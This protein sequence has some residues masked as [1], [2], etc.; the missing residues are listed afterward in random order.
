[1]VD[2]RHR[3][4][5]AGEA[6]AAE[7][8]EIL[9]FTIEDRNARVGRLEVDIVARDEHGFVVAEVR[10]RKEN[11]PVDPFESM[12]GAKERNI[13]NALAMMDRTGKGRSVYIGVTLINDEPA[14]VEILDVA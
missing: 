14:A 3:K 6:A 4:G 12:K 1:M 10:S 8:L 5:R 2:E 7:A 13:E 9:G 11:D